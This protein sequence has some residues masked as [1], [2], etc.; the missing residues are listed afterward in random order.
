[1]VGGCR[2]QHPHI[3]PVLSAGDVRVTAQL[4]DTVEDANLWSERFDGSLDDVFAIQESI[5]H[6]IVGALRVWLSPEERRGMQERPI[7]DLRAYDCYLRARHEIWSFTRAGAERA[8]V[9]LTHGLQEAGDN[10]LIP[11]AARCGRRKQRRACGWVCAG[12]IHD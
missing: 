6:S 12:G 1:M 10:A 9:L 5:A 4:V 8:I 2:A 3:V 7:P 11:C